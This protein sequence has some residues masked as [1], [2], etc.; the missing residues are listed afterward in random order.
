M[1]WPPSSSDATARPVAGRSRSVGRYGLL[2]AERSSG[3]R[4]GNVHHAPAIEEL[5]AAVAEFPDALPADL[6]TRARE[7][8]KDAEQKQFL[9]G[10]RN[11]LD[12]GLALPVRTQRGDESKQITRTSRS[13]SQ[14]V[15]RPHAATRRR[16]QGFAAR[17]RQNELESSPR[18]WPGERL[19]EPTLLVAGRERTHEVATDAPLEQSIGG[20]TRRPAGR[21]RASTSSSRE[22]NTTCSVAGSIRIASSGLRPA[23]ASVRLATPSRR[24]SRVGTIASSIPCRA[25]RS[26]ALTARPRDPRVSRRKNGSLSLHVPRRS[27]R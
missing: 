9:N 23:R 14:R 12:D 24:T 3:A 6:T 10:R 16:R 27:L 8:V 13:R 18:L 26:S 5:E 25:R 17:G 1:S 7:L 15:R 20:G 19:A 21:G 11:A 22:S 2:Q 4:S